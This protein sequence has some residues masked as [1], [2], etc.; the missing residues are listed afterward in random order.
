MCGVWSSKHST[1]VRDFLVWQVGCPSHCKGPS[2]MLQKSVIRNKHNSV[3]L[4]HESSKISY[5]FLV[6][7]VGVYSWSRG[8]AIKESRKFGGLSEGGE[9]KMHFALHF[10][11]AFNLH[12]KSLPGAPGWFS[13]LRSVFRS[14]HDLMVHEF[15][16]HDGL[17]ADSSEPGVCFGFSASLSL[18][19]PHLHCLSKLNKC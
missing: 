9:I 14:G 1:A 12:N 15:E 6:L 10:I 16:P 18:L 4:E 19:F 17:C 8:L 5:L 7:T 13:R 3:Q 2:S 11:V